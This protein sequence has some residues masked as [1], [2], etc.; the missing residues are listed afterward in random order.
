MEPAGWVI[1]TVGSRHEDQADEN[2][3]EAK[4]Q[5][6]LS[7]PVLNRSPTA[8][9]QQPGNAA[10]DD[11]APA[12][13]DG[14]RGVSSSHNSVDELLRRIAR[15]VSARQAREHKGDDRGNHNHES[16]GRSD[17]RDGRQHERRSRQTQQQ[18]PSQASTRRSRWDAASERRYSSSTGSREENGRSSR[19]HADGAGGD[20]AA[21]REKTHFGTAAAAAAVSV[22]EANPF[23]EGMW[24]S[25]SC[26]QV[27]QAMFFSPGS[28][29][30]A[31]PTEEFK[32]LEGIGCTK[33]TA[34][35][36]GFT[37][38]DRNENPYARFYLASSRF[39]LPRDLF[40]QTYHRRC[41][42]HHLKN[43]AQTPTR[44]IS[45][46]PQSYPDLSLPAVS[47]RPQNSSQSS[48]TAARRQSLLRPL[49]LLLLQRPRH[50]K[51]Q[52]RCRW[53][54]P[55]SPGRSTSAIS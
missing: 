51:T 54:W 47:P 4:G 50:Q 52:N 17:S 16:S 43:N 7:E 38:S 18:Q 44:A 30:P 33:D 34:V 45:T 53:R 49:L 35:G 32:E 26:R 19:V 9:V 13:A 3:R 12:A 5:P 11:A 41:P 29:L 10:A 8:A 40:L 37:K 46:N 20:A 23:T 28:A 15:D 39:A 6:L 2:G 55:T 31:G 24:E 25:A 48:S 27:L 42:P 14:N 22:A 1:D 21:G 36:Y